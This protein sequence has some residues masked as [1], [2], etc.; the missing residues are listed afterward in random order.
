[1]QVFSLVLRPSSFSGSFAGEVQLAS[2]RFAG[3][4]HTSEKDLAEAWHDLDLCHQFRL[5][6]ITGHAHE[7]LRCMLV[8]CIIPCCPSSG[9]QQLLAHEQ[10]LLLILLNLEC[11]ASFWPLQPKLLLTC[12]KC[13]VICRSIKGDSGPPTP[14]TVKLFFLRH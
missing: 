3:L 9:L 4:S 13:T 12:Y 6:H 2:H 8:G 7:L 5:F 11:L 1:M 10:V 14:L